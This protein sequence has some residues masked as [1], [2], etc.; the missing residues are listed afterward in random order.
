MIKPLEKKP[1]KK[2]L[3]QKSQKNTVIAKLFFLATLIISALLLS[4]IVHSHPRPQAA[5]PTPQA[6]LGASSF[7]DFQKALKG[8]ADIVGKKGQELKQEILRQA[9]K[10]MAQKQGEIESSVSAIL[11]QNAVKPLLEQI[12]RLPEEQKKILKEAVCK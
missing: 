1:N 12:N 9:A 4:T 3:Q 6:V 8:D 11:Y 7:D 5:K 10:L 2:E